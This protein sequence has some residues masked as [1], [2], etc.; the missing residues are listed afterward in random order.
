MPPGRINIDDPD[1]D[2]DA[3]HRLL[4][5]GLPFTGEV[6]ERSGGHLISLDTYVDGLLEGLG[7]EWY[8]DGTLRSRGRAASNRAVGIHQEW[9][10]NGTLARTQS[11]SAGGDLI[12]DT[13]WDEHG[14]PTRSWSA[15]LP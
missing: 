14:R 6:E 10:P 3:A 1:V 15:P 4:Y 12:Q 11:F 7:R 9:H 5:R 13:E 2:M 8:E